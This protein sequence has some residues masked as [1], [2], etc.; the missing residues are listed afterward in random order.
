MFQTQHS[1]HQPGRATGVV[2]TDGPHLSHTAWLSERVLLIVAAFEAREPIVDAGAL[3]W[4]LQFGDTA[5]EAAEGLVLAS[6]DGTVVL[7]LARVAGAVR[8]G[9]TPPGLCLTLGSTRLLA[10]SA[11][12]AGVLVDLRTLVRESLA[13]LDPAARAPIVPWLASATAL[14][15]DADGGAY[16]L[17]RSLHQARES[18]REPRRAC[19]IAPDEPRG[20]QVD[21]LLGIDART[22]WVKGWARD[23]DARLSGLTAVSPEGGRGEF[24]ERALRL[25]R[26]DVEQFY[27]AGAAGNVEERSGFVGLVELDAPSRLQTGWIIEL[28]DALGESIEVEAPVVVRDLD[29]VR[30]SIL[31]DFALARRPD[32]PARAVLFEPALARLQ[33][34][35]AAEVRVDRVQT[36]GQLAADPDVSVIVPLY[37]RID[38]LEH[39]LTQFARDPEMRCADVLYVLDSPE[40]AEALE[41]LAPEMHALTGVPFRVVTLARNAGFSGANNA[42]AGFARGRKL[43]LLNSDVLPDRPG[44]LGTMARF[45]DATPGIGALGAKLLY[46]DDSLQHAGMHFLRSP[47]STTWENMHYYKGL[48]RTSPGANVARRVPAVS[49]ACLMI[50]RER[51]EQLG[52]LSGR[53]VQGDYEDSDLCLRLREEGLDSWYLPDAELYHLEAQ[54]YPTEL[55]R[56]TS[57]YNTWLHSHLWGERIADLM[58]S[59]DEEIQP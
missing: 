31:T 56:A 27:A 42:A 1:A 30:T 44:W 21:T 6:G 12:L 23:A 3:E 8:V 2:G 18:L 35:L 24:L 15:A 50:E 14:H 53:F 46:E 26:P 22:Y 16:S 33:A 59:T 47:G 49:G 5:P 25:A 38:F 41:R 4:S 36:Y 58:A 57:A 34:R 29:A 40:D 7:V 51:Y 20:L 43:V 9:A 11:D 10:S 55:R 45:F 19:L 28:S 37:R 48:A 32:D 39:Q 52:G 17:S 54:S 13:G